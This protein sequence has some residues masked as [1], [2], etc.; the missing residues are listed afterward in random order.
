[1]ESIQNNTSNAKMNIKI[2]VIHRELGKMEELSKLIGVKLE[3]LSK[4][5]MGT[6]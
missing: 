3:L 1:M 2:T 5:Y 6:Y 4:R